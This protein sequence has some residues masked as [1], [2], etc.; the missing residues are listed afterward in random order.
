MTKQNN[1]LRS[2]VFGR[3]RQDIL[4]GRYKAGTELTEAALGAEPGGRGN[5]QIT[6]CPGSTALCAYL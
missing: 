2:Q 1:S 5:L 4:C 6:G 3:I